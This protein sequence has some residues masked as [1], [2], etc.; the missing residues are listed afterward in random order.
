MSASSE[1]DTESLLDRAVGGDANAVTAL[2]LRHRARLK[3]MV[4]IHMD[5]RAAARFDPSDV[6]QDALLDAQRELAAYLRDRPL[7][8]YPWLR[9][10]TWEQLL[11]YHRRHVHAQM[12]S[13]RR[14]Q[15]SGDQWTEQARHELADYLAES[16]TSPSARFL[17]EELHQ[18]VMSA[19]ARLSDRD[20]EILTLRFLE[21]LSQLETAAVLG[22]TEGSVNMR[23]LRAL[24]RLRQMLQVPG[25]DV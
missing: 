2:L 22:I 14:E 4:A 16:V 8:F 20:R 21:R 1:P 25:H 24:A 3:R 10:L 5:R 17:R 19:L 18:R 15:H 12:R 6:V 9:Q 7:P 23:Q 13:I 11:R